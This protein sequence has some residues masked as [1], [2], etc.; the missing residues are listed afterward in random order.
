MV[1]PIL[2]LVNGR[3]VSGWD[4][5]KGKLMVGKGEDHGSDRTED[6][7]VIKTDEI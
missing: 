5:T 1:G 2:Y 6:C 4:T 3:D 7:G